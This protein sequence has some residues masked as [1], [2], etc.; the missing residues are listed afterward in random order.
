MKF[1]LLF[2][3]LITTSMALRG[4]LFRSRRASLDSIIRA[5]ASRN[6]LRF[7]SDGNY[8]NWEPIEFEIFTP[9]DFD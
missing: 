1:L 8:Y 3:L 6:F 9:G 2:F 5:H 4:A 7:G